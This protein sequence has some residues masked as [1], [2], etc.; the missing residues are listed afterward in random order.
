MGPAASP[1]CAIAS[2]TRS[3]RT[4]MFEHL[5]GSPPEVPRDEAFARV[6]RRATRIRS[7]RMAMS[8]LAAV[9]VVAG[10]AGIGASIRPSGVSAPSAESAYQFNALRSP[11][12][13]GTNVPT[14]ALT[15]LVFVTADDGFALAAHQGRSLLAKTVD[16]GNTWSVVNDH[17]PNGYGESDGFPGEFEFTDALH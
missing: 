12:S 1:R 10:A 8:A 14:A 6:V 16:G 13:E 7:R 4:A 3:G 11:L 17:L 15:N 9:V 2:G 5:D